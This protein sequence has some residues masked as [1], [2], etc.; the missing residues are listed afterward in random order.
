MASVLSASIVDRACAPLPN[1]QRAVL[2][3]TG[4]RLTQDNPEG[5]A[6]L[7]NRFILE[8]AGVAP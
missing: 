2:P 7:M 1:H 8:L 5:F 6:A 4:H 3:A